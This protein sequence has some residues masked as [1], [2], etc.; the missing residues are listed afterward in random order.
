VHINTIV[1]YDK[2]SS[3]DEIPERDVTHLLSLYLFMNEL[4]ISLTKT[5]DQKSRNAEAR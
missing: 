1:Q 4:F 2:S 3:R 5:H